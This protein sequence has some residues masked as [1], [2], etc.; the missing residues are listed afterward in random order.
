MENIFGKVVEIV[1]EHTGVARNQILTGK[2][3]KCV[4]C[5]AILVCSLS[6]LGFSDSLISEYL[7]VTRQGVNKLK[8]SFPYRKK[9]NLILATTS[10]LISNH[11]ATE[12]IFSNPI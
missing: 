10:Q 5:R 3:E 7:N 8:N 9:H 4:N 12:K 6:E 1:S 11:I 2:T